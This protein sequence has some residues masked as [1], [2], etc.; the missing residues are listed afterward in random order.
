LAGLHRA[1]AWHLA[2]RVERFFQ[3]PELR[4]L[5]FKLSTANR[6]AKIRSQHRVSPADAIHL[7]CAA[8]ASTDLFLTHDQRLKGKFVEGIQF[9]I[10]LDTNLF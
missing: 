1:E 10:D 8:E 6:Y 2:T 4:V 9:I 3:S 7:A 5:D